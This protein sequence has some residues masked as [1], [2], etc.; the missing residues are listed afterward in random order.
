[1]KNGALNHT[2]T[3][4]TQKRAQAAS[5]SQKMRPMP[6]CSRPQ[7]K[8]PKVGSNSSRQASMLMAA[9][10]THGT[11]SM[12]RHLRWP[13][14]GMLCTKWATAKPMTALMATAMRA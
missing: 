12:P 5:P 8:A 6:R 3:R 1:M 2:V 4:T 13:F 14:V 10:I 7:S 9:G 11:R